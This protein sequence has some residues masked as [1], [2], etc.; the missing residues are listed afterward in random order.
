MTIPSAWF[1]LL[2]TVV[3]PGCATNSETVPQVTVLPNESGVT[4]SSFQAHGP[5]NLLGERRDIRTNRRD[6]PDV[7][8]GV[9]ANAKSMEPLHNAE[10]R[11]FT[12]ASGLI[13]VVS[14]ERPAAYNTR[15]KHFTAEV[16]RWEGL[17]ESN[18]PL[19][20]EA[21]AELNN[22]QLS[23]IPWTNGG[24][25]F[26]AKL[27]RRSYPWGKALLFLTS[28]IQGSTGG[29]VNNDMLVLV[30]QGITN[31]GRYAVSAHLQMRHPMLPDSLW[32]KRREGRV[33]FSIDDE[34]KEAERWLDAQADDSFDPPFGQYER[35]FEALRIAHGRPYLPKET[36][37]APA[38]R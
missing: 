23:E 5:Y 38:A 36:A 24:N 1:L 16:R 27:R 19:G 4:I 2:S 18:A 26:Y 8:T 11:F 34:T 20:A 10:P 12:P 6:P 13:Q 31:D 17:I 33:V 30:L 29:P 3:L 15:Y 25:C 21:Q 37:K 14:I 35:F 32:D 28:Y 22:S 9:T 7:P